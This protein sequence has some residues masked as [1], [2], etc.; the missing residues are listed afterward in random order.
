MIQKLRNNQKGF[1]LIELMIVIAI[2]GILAAI[3]IPQFAAYRMRSFNSSSISDVRNSATSQVAMFGDYQ[4]YGVSDTVV[5]GAAMPGNA[6]GNGAVLTGPSGGPVG[7]IPIVTA[8]DANG[9]PQGTQIPLGNNVMFVSHTNAGA[10][11]IIANTSFTAASKHTTGNTYYATDGDVT[12]IFFEEV[13]G[14]DGTALLVGDCPA[15]V[16][17]VDD[18]TGVAGPGGANWI[19][20]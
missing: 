9:R 5:A 15:S 7:N 20:R 1:T 10:A 16:S 6:G 13:A 12:A 17:G 19:A 14:S 18:L 2:I 3:A 8:D 4:V 11:G